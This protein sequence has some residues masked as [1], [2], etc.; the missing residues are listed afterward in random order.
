MP[1]QALDLGRGAQTYDRTLGY[2]CAS[3]SGLI[4]EEI[5]M[6]VPVWIVCNANLNPAHRR[7]ENRI[8]ASQI[9]GLR[10]GPPRFRMLG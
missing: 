5:S 9:D 4:H 8:C 6:I 3:I 7:A 10:E 2:A 1:P